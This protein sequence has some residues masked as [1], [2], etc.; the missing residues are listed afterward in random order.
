MRVKDLKEF[1]KIFPEEMEI[2]IRTA[3]NDFAQPISKKH[4]GVSLASHEERY[5]LE[6]S[7]VVL[8]AYV[9]EQPH[10]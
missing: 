1:L 5:G 2:L 6:Q 4:I 9:E 10:D 3:P 8:T 7:K